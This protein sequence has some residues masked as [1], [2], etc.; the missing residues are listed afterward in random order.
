M[1]HGPTIRGLPGIG[2]PAWTFDL[3]PD[4]LICASLPIMTFFLVQQLSFW[5]ISSSLAVEG[6]G[7]PCEAPF[8]VGV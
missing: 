1:T 2:R 4:E 8:I 5:H 6:R 7:S 3:F